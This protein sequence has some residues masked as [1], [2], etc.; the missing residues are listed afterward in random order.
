MMERKKGEWKGYE[1]HNIT[2]FWCVVLVFVLI[3]K[4]DSCSI[5]SLTLCI[6]K[7]EEA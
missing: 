4:T 5:I 3:N 6:N 2:I 7:Q 1:S